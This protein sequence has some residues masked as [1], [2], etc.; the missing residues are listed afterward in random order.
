M[1]SDHASDISS[2]SLE[3]R[4]RRHLWLH[5][6]RM[7]SYQGNDVPVIVRGSGQYVYDTQGKRYLD[8]LPCPIWLT[9]RPDRPSRY[10]LPRVS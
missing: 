8:G 1:T 6:T 4:A 5:F 7:S 2:D 9:N 3:A 10:R